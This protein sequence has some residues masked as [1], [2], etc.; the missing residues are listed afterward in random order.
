MK[1]NFQ[2]NDYFIHFSKWKETILTTEAIIEDVLKNLNK[3]GS[4]ITLIINN[5]KI[6]IY[7]NTP[8]LISTSLIKAFNETSLD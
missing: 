6:Y 7:K 1:K 2:K 5:K 3:T 8:T 4:R